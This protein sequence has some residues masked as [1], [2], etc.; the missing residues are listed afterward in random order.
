VSTITSQSEE[1]L[2]YRKPY[3][4]YQISNGGG[5]CVAN[6]AAGMRIGKKL[7]NR[8]QCVASVDCVGSE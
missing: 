1:T 6:W 5:N 3:K 7:A 4:E 2:E 8:L